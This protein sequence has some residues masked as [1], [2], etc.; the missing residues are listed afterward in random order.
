MRHVL[1]IGDCQCRRQDHDSSKDQS[2]DQADF[3]RCVARA[4]ILL[5]TAAELR[6]DSGFRA[7]GLSSSG[8]SRYNN[9]KAHLDGTSEAQSSTSAPVRVG[10]VMDERTL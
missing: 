4:G 10:S 6:L 8:S 9:C 7:L 1:V 3:P 5:L 2:A